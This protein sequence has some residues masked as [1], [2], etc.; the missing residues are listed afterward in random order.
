[1]KYYKVIRDS[2]VIDA[3]EIFLRWQEKNRILV[4]C[5]PE[6]AQFVQSYD[7]S[8]V[9]RVQWLNPAPAAAGTFETVEAALIDEQE[10]L[11]LRAVLDD[12]ET[13]PVPDPFVPEPE[14]EPDPDPE[15]D[16]SDQHMTVQ[17]MRDK[18]AE[19]GATIQMLTDCIL[20]MSEV[21]YS[22]M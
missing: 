19:Q 15:Q 13:V 11:D 22:G 12:G 4:S 3:G 2:C 5:E 14:P 17:Q 8:T 21:V 10:F 16:V 7:G 18:I 1:M 6:N 20:E 9:W